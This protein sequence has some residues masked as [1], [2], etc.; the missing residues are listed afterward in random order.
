[1][2]ILTVSETTV[3][4]GTEYV[5]NSA[6][7]YDVSAI[8]IDSTHVLVAYQDAGNSDYGTAQILTVNGTTITIGTKYVFNSGTTSNISTTLIDSTHVLVAYRDGGNSGYGTVGIL[9]VSETTVTI[10]TEYVFNSAKTYDVSA[11]LID[12]THVL[13]VYDD[14]GNSDYG[15]AQILTISGTT[16]TVGTEYVFNSA[17]TSSI[18]ATLIDSTHVLVTYMDAGNSNYG[19]AQILTISE[20]SIN[21][22]TEYVFNSG[23]TSYISSTL[24]DS[25]H[26]L[27]AYKDVGNSNYGT[28]QVLTISGT[29]ITA[30]GKYVFNSAITFDISSILID[31]AYV[32]IVYDNTGTPS[33]SIQLL[34]V[35]YVQPSTTTIDGLTK[36]TCTTTD[37]GKVWALS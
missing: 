37:T 14:G 15:T 30:G 31:S 18:S 13:V 33:G 26:V 27:V 2:G 12:S 10:G 22:N 36:S 4:I 1:V 32:L 21:T 7:T 6:K 29:T 8:L 34:N 24:I 16:M 17:D 9:T 19:T 11:I 23:V 35:K 3:T 25:T 20:T 28:A 5:F